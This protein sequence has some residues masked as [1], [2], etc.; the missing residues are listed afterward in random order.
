M[1]APLLSVFEGERW[2][3][4]FRLIVTGNIGGRKLSVAG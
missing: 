3:G 4:S 2:R 1:A